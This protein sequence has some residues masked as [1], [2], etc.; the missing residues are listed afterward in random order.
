MSSRAANVKEHDYW[1]MVRSSAA[2]TQQ[3]CALLIFFS[4]FEFIRQ[5]VI[6]FAFL[7]AVNA[8][9]AIVGYVILRFRFRIP[10]PAMDA[11][12]SSLLFCAT[13]S[14]L[15]P[16]LRTLTKS[17]AND[18]ISALASFLAFVHI[19]SHDYNYVNSGI[20]RFSGTISLNAA[21]FTAVLLGSR[22]QSNEHVFAFILFA[23]EIFAVFPIFQREVKRNSERA[24]LATA[25]AFFALSA[26]LTWPI[27]RLL[28]VVSSAFVVFLSLIC[29]LW[30]M[31]VQEYKNEILGP[32]DIAHI[33]PEQ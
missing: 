6:S 9:L 31:H 24:H 19:V 17:Y 32:W 15:S 23:I 4:V 16:V 13:L 28:C 5:D 20:G 18:T 12:S 10:L 21:I 25:V 2:I 27:S 22:L 29:P 8:V 1:G 33:Q 11:L 7:M 26:C 14:I 30:F 3:I